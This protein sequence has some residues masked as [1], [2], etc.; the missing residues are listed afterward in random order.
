MSGQAG[1]RRAPA[2]LALCTLA[3][4]H[5]DRVD[6]AYG[7]PR[8]LAQRT[9]GLSEG[10]GHPA[11][12]AAHDG[13]L[14]TGIPDRRGHQIESREKPSSTRALSY[15]TPSYLFVKRDRV[16]HIQGHTPV[17]KTSSQAARDGAKTIKWES[18]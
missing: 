13:L 6:R 17:V 3:Y 4:L 11:D 2:T 1:D 7:C 18:Y 16:R 10:F 15:R 12:I 9:V 14:Q 5:A 8:N